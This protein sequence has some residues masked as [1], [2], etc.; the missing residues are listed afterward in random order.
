MKGKGILIHVCYNIGEP[1]DTELRAI[2]LSQED[3]YPQFPL[4]VWHL[5]LRNSQNQ[6]AKRRLTEAVGATTRELLN[7]SYS[8]KR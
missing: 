4:Y 7:N 2:S 8:S 3:K 1:E 5:E 6:R